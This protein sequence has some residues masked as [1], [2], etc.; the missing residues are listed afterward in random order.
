[1]LLE[2][3]RS[4]IAE[5]TLVLLLTRQGRAPRV[6]GVQPVVELPERGDTGMS[7]A[8][9]PKAYPPGGRLSAHVLLVRRPT[10]LCRGRRGEPQAVGPVDGC[11]GPR[12]ERGRR[13]PARPVCGGAGVLGPDPP[14]RLSEPPRSDQRGLS[15]SCLAHLDGH[16]G[17]TH[18][19]PLEASSRPL[20]AAP[21]PGIA[22]RCS[23]RTWGRRMAPVARL[24]H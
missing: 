5:P 4:F 19:V 14:N 16:G 21:H 10:R 17:G 18:H 1:M 9:F 15:P 22:S 2:L 12:H 6:V 20:L 7:L 24:G 8:G 13:A 23:A 3:A 11:G